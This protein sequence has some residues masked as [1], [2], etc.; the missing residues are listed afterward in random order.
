MPVRDLED[1][2]RVYG[3]ALDVFV[4]ATALFQRSPA[5]KLIMAHTGGHWLRSWSP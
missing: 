2:P 3:A 1:D 4:Y 5:A